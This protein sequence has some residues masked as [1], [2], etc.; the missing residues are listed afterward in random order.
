MM[1]CFLQIYSSHLVSVEICMD[2]ISCFL[3]GGLVLVISFKFFHFHSQ[4]KENFSL[5]FCFLIPS[6]QL[7]PTYATADIIY[8]KSH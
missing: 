8:D 7:L 3:L 6:S 1:R 4:G 5:M 2:S